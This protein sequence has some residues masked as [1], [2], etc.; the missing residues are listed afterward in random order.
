[1]PL[2]PEHIKAL[3]PYKA[4]KPIGEL[5]RELGLK[6]IVK[7]ASNE[8]PLGV[9]PK[10]L[11]ALK[12]AVMSVN[13][14]PSADGFELRKALADR[15]DVKIDNVFLGHGSEGIISIIMRTFLLDD[16]EAITSEGS[17]ITFNIAAQSRGIKLVKAPLKDY[18]IDLQAIAGRITDKTKVIYL[19]NPNNPTGTIFKVHSFLEFIKQ[20][21]PRVLVILD[22]A[23]FEF[24]RED[25]AYPDSMQYR[26]DN[27]ITLRT[28]SKAYG[29][30]G[31]RVGYGFAHEHFISNLMKIKLAFE[32]SSLAL[33]AGTAALEDIDFLEQT[34]HL[35]RQGLKFFYDLFDRLGL[36]YLRS[37]ANF[38]TLV[39]DSEEQVNRLYDR[40]L[41]KG[42][43]VR[44]LKAFGLPN[45]IRV[46]TGLEEEN[47][48]FAKALENVL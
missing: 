39:F 30:A 40:L 6:K 9:S 24:A 36:R 3:Q 2:V 38:V 33:A 32:P 25:P 46:S 47:A 41:R 42:V 15:Y 10:A 45:C 23:Y 27:V 5:Q 11:S 37:H 7:L 19:A 12:K 4:G 35:N 18:H 44:P 29:L 43:I 48:F 22:E 31:V 17:F 13:R 20:V 28:F 21:P 1:M 34:L 14:Y 16:E 26:L 8:N